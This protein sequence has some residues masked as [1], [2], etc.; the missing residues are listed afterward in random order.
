M[1]SWNAEYDK[2]LGRFININIDIGRNVGFQRLAVHHLILKPG[3]R[4][5]VPHAESLEEEF[6]FVLKGTPDLW[7]NGFVHPLQ[8]GHAVGFQAG[9]GIAHTLINNT[10]EDVHLLVAGEKTKKENRFIYPINPELKTEDIAWWKDWPQQ[11]LGSH[12]GLPGPINANEKSTS[13]P[14]YLIYCPELS[15][16][17]PFHYPGD[18]ETFGEGFRLSTAMELK[19]LGIWHEC[20]PSGRRSAFPHAHTHEEEF[21]FILKGKAKIW[22]NGFVKEIFEGEGAAFPSNTGLSHVIIN[23]S[24]DE[25]VYLCIGEALDF[26]D[27][28]ILYPLNLLRRKECERKGWYWENPPMHT[29]GNHSGRPV[30]PFDDHLC[31]KPCSE[32]DWPTVFEIYQQ[33]PSYFKKVDGCL[34]TQET[35]QH[36]LID[37]PSKKDPKYF[38]EFLVIELNQEP[39]GVLDLHVHHPEEKVCYLGLLLIKENLF[40]RKIGTRCF[41]LAEDYIRRALGCTKIRLGVSDE[42]DVSGYWQKMGFQF[43]GSS[44]QWKGKEKTATVREFD[45]LITQA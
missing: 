31:F 1:E 3:T 36:D 40:S 44:Y 30:Q 35:A 37:S 39:I 5:S 11:Q 42:N 32:K 16:R 17:K 19:A 14:K 28:K 43:N 15:K 21:V 38:K 2:Y 33:S 13:N 25:L 24:D 27:E 7:L 20:L 9:T 10:L 45:K 6:V 26:P 29:W 34:P 22:I 12:S 18:N 4:S 41:Q 8:P 23:D